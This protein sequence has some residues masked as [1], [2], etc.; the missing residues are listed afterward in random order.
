MPQLPQQPS[1]TGL[2]HGKKP[3][4]TSSKG[5]HTNLLTVVGISAVSIR[6]LTQPLSDALERVQTRTGNKQQVA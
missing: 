3:L 4:D 6:R 5:T 2:A 1:Q